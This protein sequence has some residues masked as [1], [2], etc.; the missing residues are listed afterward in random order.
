MPADTTPPT[1]ATTATPNGEKPSS[2]TLGLGLLGLIF[3]PMAL[4][5]WLIAIS[6]RSGMITPRRAILFVS[7]VFLIM[8]AG[9]TWYTTSLEGPE[10]FDLKSPSLMN[11]YP[12]STYLFVG[13][14][15]LATDFWTG[16]I[17]GHLWK[18]ASNPRNAILVTI[19]AVAFFVIGRTPLVLHATYL[20]HELT[21]MVTA[22]KMSDR[23]LEILA[24]IK[25]KHPDVSISEYRKEILLETLVHSGHDKEK[26]REKW[27][28][29][30][31]RLGMLEGETWEQ[32]QKRKNCKDADCH[33]QAPL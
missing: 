12:H 21:A 18:T 7:V 4:M 24:D 27:R 8:I 28:K 29:S 32:F 3:A 30:R 23:S 13:V 11:S 19:A 17:L 14:L 2:A 33:Q 6:S 31:E 16:V 20:S 22:A 10:I 9:G 15:F 1:V 25:Q 5:G 26:I